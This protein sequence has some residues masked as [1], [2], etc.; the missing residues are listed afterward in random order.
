MQ[1][2]DGGS[3]SRIA[4]YPIDL[5]SFPSISTSSLKCIDSSIDER[6][7]F[8]AIRRVTLL[9]RRNR[10]HMPV[11]WSFNDTENIFQQRPKPKKKKGGAA[12]PQ[13]EDTKGRAAGQLLQLLEHCGV[14]AGSSIPILL[15]SESMLCGEPSKAS[16]TSTHSQLPTEPNVR[17]ERA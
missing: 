9:P 5:F 6:T 17:H 2:S 10:Y 4:K 14:A 7:Y 1:D 8:Q 16:L 13:H 12:A 15:I 3:L 11:K